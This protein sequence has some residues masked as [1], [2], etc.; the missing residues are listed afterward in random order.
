M[1]HAHEHLLEA[2]GVRVL[3]A[4]HRRLEQFV[5]RANLQRVGRLR[6]ELDLDAAHGDDAHLERTVMRIAEPE[7]GEVLAVQVA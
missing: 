3:G 4:G 1:A 2:I 5:A 6:V 7:R